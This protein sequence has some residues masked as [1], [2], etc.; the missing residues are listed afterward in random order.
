LTGALKT[1]G[2]P[3][4]E[5]LVLAGSV[6]TFRLALEVAVDP[7]YDTDKV[8][9][10]V[11]SALRAAYSFD[12]RSFGEPVYLSRID[13]VAQAVP[14]VVAIDVRRLYTGGT[15]S[16]SDR[17]LAQQAS[18]APDGSPIP[19]G[20]LVLDSHPLDGLGVMKP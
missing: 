19:A 4:V 5:I 8:L 7:A 11:E 20:L 16:L 18:V 2:D 3:T 15:P 10:G 9:G 6:E 17:L 1:F 14:G 12:V 13:A